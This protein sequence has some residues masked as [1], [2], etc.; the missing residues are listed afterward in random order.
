M[1]MPWTAAIVGFGRS[2]QRRVLATFSSHDRR[3]S[4]NQPDG[5]GLAP[6]RR[7][8]T[9][10]YT[11]RTTSTLQLRGEHT[12]STDE[13][14]LG[15]ALTFREPVVDWIVAGSN[16]LLYQ[17]DKRQFGA[18]FDLFHVCLQPE[19]TLCLRCASSDALVGFGRVG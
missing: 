7:S 3:W 18:L 19:A 15:D 16:A 5:Q 10:E 6:Y 13:W 1:H 2:R 4:P 14:E 8:E 11:E 9:L 17:P 12:L